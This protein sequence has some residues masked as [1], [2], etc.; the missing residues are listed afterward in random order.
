LFGAWLLHDP[1]HLFL[2]GPAIEIAALAFVSGAA[3]L[4]LGFEGRALSKTP[5][6]AE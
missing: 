2:M 6:L 5:A 3:M 4:A 1:L